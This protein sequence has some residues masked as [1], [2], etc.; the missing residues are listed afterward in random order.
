M[1]HIDNITSIFW[2]A[3]IIL[4]GTKLIVSVFTH[5]EHQV[6]DKNNK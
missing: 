4:H 1:L 2:S 6:M 3:I 5:N